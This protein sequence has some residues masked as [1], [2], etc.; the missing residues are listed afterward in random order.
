MDNADTEVEREW[1]RTPL[2]PLAVSE[3]EGG[4]NTFRASHADNEEAE[5]VRHPT[6]WQ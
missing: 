5:K 1:G 3:G 6:I 2:L 4:N